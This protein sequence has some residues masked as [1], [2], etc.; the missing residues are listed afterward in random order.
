[1]KKLLRHFGVFSML[2]AVILSILP[3]NAFAHVDNSEGYSKLSSDDG[4][5]HYLLSLDILELGRVVDLGIGTNSTTGDFE[6]ALQTNRDKLM[7]YVQGKIS[8]FNHGVKL[9]GEIVDTNVDRKTDREY[10]NITITFPIESKEPPA[11]QI[12][13]DIFFIDN[14]PDHRNI[15]TYD[16][17]GQKGQFVFTSDTPDLELG[18]TSLLNQIVPFVKLGFHHILI[19]LDHIL[20]IIALVITSKKFTDVVKILTL[21]TLAHSVTLGLT[22]LNIL[23]LPPEIIE[24]LIALSV[25][26]VAIERFLNISDK[27]RYS[28]VFIFGLIHGVGFAGALELS[29]PITWLSIF[30][31]ITFNAGVEFGQLLIVLV[32]FPILYVV[33]KYKWSLPATYA[34]NGI[35]FFIGMTWYF[36]RFLG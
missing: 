2:A 7:E 28:V 12:S 33:R 19:G 11:L 13:Y 15:V 4:G 5:F 31:V 9:E 18:E 27:Y 26:F 17:E 10:A 29:D 21:F 23:F 8:V 35:I 34:V 30:P 6:K 14:D 22:A 3:L 36:Q 25:A 1:M 32:L 16:I 24:P 20:F